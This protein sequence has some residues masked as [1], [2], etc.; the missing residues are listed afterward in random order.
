MIHTKL[1]EKF[2]LAV[3]KVA[4]AS[5]WTLHQYEYHGVEVRELQ[6]WEGNILRKLQMNLNDAPKIEVTIRKD[7]FRNCPKLRMWL[8]KNLPMFPYTAELRWRSVDPVEVA[9]TVDEYERILSA[10]LKRDV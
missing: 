9:L 3:Q 6:K 10:L 7:S 1:P 2:E 4:L 8:H 5:G